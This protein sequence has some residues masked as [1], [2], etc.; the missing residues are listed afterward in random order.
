M[1]LD[2]A[3]DIAA[4]HEIAEPWLRI[5]TYRH[6]RGEGLGTE[7]PYTFEAEVRV[8][9]EAPLGA[10]FASAAAVG[11]YF[12]L[13]SQEYAKASIYFQGYVGCTQLPAALLVTQFTQDNVAAWLQSGQ[14]NTLTLPALQAVSGSLTVTV[15]N[16]PRTIASVS[17]LS[18]W[19][20]LSSYSAA[21][22]IL[23]TG[24]NTT[25]PTEASQFTSESAGIAG[26][27]VLR[28][29]WKPVRAETRSGSVRSTTAR[30]RRGNAHLR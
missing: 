23:Q 2:S 5:T 9:P 4:V 20:T 21:A 17:A 24:L 8:D 28:E 16:Y 12:G 30:P 29:G 1:S 15:D 13:S 19:S 10:E 6:A 22:T 25:L 27:T 18:G 11:A 14:I 3:R 7:G 26:L